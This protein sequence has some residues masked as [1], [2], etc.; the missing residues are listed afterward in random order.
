MAGK[1]YLSVNAVHSTS[2]VIDGV[3]V[4]FGWLVLFVLVGL[5]CFG[6]FGGCKIFS[7]SR[8]KARITR[9]TFTYHIAQLISKHERRRVWGIRHADIGAHLIEHVWRR[10]CRMNNKD[11]FLE[12]MKY[13][14]YK[15]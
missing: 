2:T 6:W 9:V 11:P 8:I 1:T 10:D 4:L 3:L 5:V 14:Q 15:A 13:L 7:R 12:I